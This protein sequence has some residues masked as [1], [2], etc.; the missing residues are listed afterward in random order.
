MEDDIT[1]HAVYTILKSML[2]VFYLFMVKYQFENDEVTGVWIKCIHCN[3][4]VTFQFSKTLTID[5]L[6]VFIKATM[7][8]HVGLS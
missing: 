7:F 4:N 1:D 5:I 3:K 6:P 8:Q 2:R